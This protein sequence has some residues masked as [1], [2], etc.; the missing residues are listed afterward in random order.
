MGGWRISFQSLH[1][2]PRGG[3]GRATG[4]STNA[5]LHLMAL[6]REAGLSEADFNINSFN[7]YN[8]STPSS[9]AC[10]P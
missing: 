10:L 6:A 8:A 3:W 7:K 2:D 9:A 4:G 5:V 1:A